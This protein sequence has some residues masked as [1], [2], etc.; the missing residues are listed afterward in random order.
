MGG[1]AVPALLGA[2]RRP[3]P[4]GRQP[5]V[6]HFP[7]NVTARAAVFVAVSFHRGN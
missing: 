7:T 6:S 5:R 2:T 1:R 4:D 3:T